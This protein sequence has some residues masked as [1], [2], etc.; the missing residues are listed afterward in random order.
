L[1]IKAITFDFWHTLLTE[2][3]NVLGLYQNKRKSILMEMFPEH[4]ARLETD[5]AGACKTESESHHRIWEQE[6]R[7]LP[8]VERVST[9]LNHLEFTITEP[10]LT[11]IVTRWEEGILD[12]P[13]VVIE[14]ARETL[15]E[16]SKH[17]RLGIISDVGFSPGRVLKRILADNDLVDYFDSL[18]F[19]DEAGRAKPHIEVFQRAADSLSATP[20]TMVHIGDLER[21]DVTGAKQAGFRAIRFV[22]IT[23]MEEG[24]TT[25]ADCIATKLTDIPALIAGF[26]RDDA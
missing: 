13:P 7:T 5:L 20:D 3:P 15:E 8:A 4:H 1:G 21:T 14:G 2:Q 6:H 19:S 17:Y 22:G 16:L 18:I 23:P 26:D 24:E 10:A 9:I 25:I 12:H 11:T